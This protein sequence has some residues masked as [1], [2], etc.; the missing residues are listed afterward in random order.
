MNYAHGSILFVKILYISNGITNVA[1][2]KYSHL[3]MALYMC[4]CA[5][6]CVYYTHQVLE[7]EHFHCFIWEN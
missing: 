3:S 4:I 2:W 7:F 5:G 1:E 6:I